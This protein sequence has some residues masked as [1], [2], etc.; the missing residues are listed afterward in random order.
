MIDII[1]ENHPNLVDAS[2]GKYKKLNFNYIKTKKLH[3]KNLNGDIW[4]DINDL[5][6]LI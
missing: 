2:I 6:K 4:L 3:D 5:N 1:P